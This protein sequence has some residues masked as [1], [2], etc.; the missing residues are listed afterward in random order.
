MIFT[1]TQKQAEK[2]AKKYNKYAKSKISADKVWCLF[3]DNADTDME[4]NGFTEIEINRFESVDGCNHVI[5]IYKS[6]V[7]Y[8]VMEVT[9][10]LDHTCGR[11]LIA[12]FIDEET[13]MVCL[14]ALEAFAKKHNSIISESLDVKPD[15]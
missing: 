8:N 11:T 2:I 15:D 3:H 12:N 5:D 1:Y 14:P 9:V 10:Y 6:E 4:D 7:D 13:Y